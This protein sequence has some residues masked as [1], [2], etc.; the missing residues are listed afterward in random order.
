MPKISPFLWFDGQAE[1]AAE[2]YVSIFPNSKITNV[3]RNSKTGPGPEGSALVVGFELDGQTISALNGGPYQKLSEAFSFV[4]YC[5]DQAEIDHYWERLGEGG[6]Y[7]V[8]GWLKDRFGLSWQVTP[9]EFFTLV[10]DPDPQKAGR[11]MTAMMQMTKFD[12]AKLREAY[13]G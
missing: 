5:Q 12:L 9:T 3:L 11:V 7:S 4:V 1:Q 10:S 6:V 2:F 8:C 13:A